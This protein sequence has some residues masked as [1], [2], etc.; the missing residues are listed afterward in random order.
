MFEYMSQL[1]LSE[2]DNIKHVIQDLFRQ[3]CILKVK[4]NPETL[5]AKDN[6][7]YHVCN[8]HR[9]FISDY[10]QVLGCELLHDSEEFIFRI[11]GDGVPTLRVS[12]TTTKLV[13]LLKLIYRDKIMGKGLHASVTN[14]KEIREYGKNTNLLPERLTS[15]EWYDALNLMKQHQMLEIP[16]AIK[17]LE[18]DT[19]L[20]IYSTVNLYCP[21]KEI[22]ALIAQYQ[23]EDKKEEE[24]DEEQESISTFVSD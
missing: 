22:N 9:E 8:Q 14:L 16:G 20:Y 21:T 3:T 6:P 1:S 18:D 15:G 4:Y 24:K 17:N 5:V 10:L 12:L 7:K 23:I 13:L 19:P 11:A 2:Q